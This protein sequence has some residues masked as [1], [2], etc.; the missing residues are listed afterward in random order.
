MAAKTIFRYLGYPFAR[1]FGSIFLE[2]IKFSSYSPEKLF[3]GLMYHAANL[4]DEG[5]SHRKLRIIVLNH[6]RKHT[7]V[8][9]GLG[10][11]TA[12]EKTRKQRCT[13]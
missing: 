3:I 9:K 1:Q 5:T 7:S 2:P 11:S 4:T 13:E 10:T 6:F 8:L 12:H